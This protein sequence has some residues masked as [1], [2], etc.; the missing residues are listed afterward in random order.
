[1]RE[2]SMLVGGAPTRE[3]HVG[4]KKIKRRLLILCVVRPNYR[5]AHVLLASR[6]HYVMRDVYNH[7][8]SMTMANRLLQKTI[9]TFVVIHFSW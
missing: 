7:A 5:H 8:C 1:M 4:T 2:I 9:M 6:A 3:M